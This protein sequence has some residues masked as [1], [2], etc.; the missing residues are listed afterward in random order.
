VQDDANR[1]DERYDGVTGAAPRA[2][3]VLERWAGLECLVPS[4]GR[5]LDV[6]CGTGGVA[7]WLA[8]RGLEVVALDVSGVAI[9]VLRRAASTAPARRI[10]TRVVDLDDG[11]PD[12]LV[13]L[14]L[15]VCQRFRDPSLYGSFIDRLDHG[16]LAFVTVLSVVGAAEPGPFHAPAG[17]LRRAFA[18]DDCEVLHEFEGDGV[19][20]AVVRRT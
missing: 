2:P 9:D 8:D 6:A 19:A 18:R 16:G 12:D 20:H 11:L 13:D 3:E 4:A 10:D 1:W 17:E 14:D 15:V 7:L 5:C